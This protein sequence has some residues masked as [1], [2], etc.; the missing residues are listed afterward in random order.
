VNAISGIE[1]MITDSPSAN[2][3]P[4]AL[5]VINSAFARWNDPAL[6]ASY[7]E[8]GRGGNCS[9]DKFVGFNKCN[10]FVYDVMVDAGILGKTLQHENENP[11]RAGFY[12]ADGELKNSGLGKANDQTFQGDNWNGDAEPGAIVSYGA[13]YAQQDGAHVTISLGSGWAIN[14]SFHSPPYSQ[15][16]G[17]NIKPDSI[18]GGYGERTVRSP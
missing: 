11:V 5:K 17:V 16:S 15:Q 4:R 18:F 13:P 12:S 1:K 8:P 2:K 9:N 14:A 10:V 3:D 6:S 7:D